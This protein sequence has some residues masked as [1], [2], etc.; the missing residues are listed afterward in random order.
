MIA[1]TGA[2]GHLGRLV[3]DE[4]L[5]R[6]VGPDEVVALAR[7]PR[8]A[9]DIAERGIEVRR[10]DYTD[11]PSLTAALQ[12]IDKLLLISSSEVGQRAAHHRAVLE[13][14]LPLGLDLLV[15]TSLINADRSGL[16]LAGEHL[17]TEEEIRKSGIPYVILRNGWY[18]ENYT[19]NLAPL[20]EHG[21]LIGSAGEG[22]VSAA[23]RADY[24]AAAAVVL[25]R[26]GHEGRTYELGGEE[27]FSL[28][29]LAAEV[30]RLAGRPV[31]YRDLTEEEHA[32]ALREAGVP[33]LY[34]RM[35]ADSDQGLGRGELVTTSTDLADLIGRPAT[36]L[37]EAIRSA[38]AG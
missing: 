16:M 9:A 27:A 25:T 4:L 33:D 10:A 12:G 13:A 1:V 32:A 15:Y 28:A 2:T 26:G 21:V 31:E 11:P 24:A 20:L 29:E 35:L 38:L 17:E 22:R 18:L 34:A 5:A 14:A 6:G 30:G 37:S 36:P 7:S 3:L 19:D 23:S 8:K